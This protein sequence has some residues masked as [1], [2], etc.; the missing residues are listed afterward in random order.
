[1]SGCQKEETMEIETKTIELNFTNDTEEAIDVWI[2]PDIEANHK[3]SVW[4]KAMIDDLK[5]NGQASL[6]AV[7]QDEDRY[8][9]RAIDADGLYYEANGITL[10]DAYRLKLILNRQDFSASLEVEDENGK[11][12]TYE[13]FCA[14]L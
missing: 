6:K 11:T 1:M 10:K 14:A 3:T 9:L 7:C 12:S 4:G 5:V 13:V 2:L 8:L